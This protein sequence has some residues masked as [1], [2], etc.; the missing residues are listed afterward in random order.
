MTHPL[1]TFDFEVL[2]AVRSET[3]P[4]LGYLVRI[5]GFR[6]VHL[7]LRLAEMG[8]VPTF[9]QKLLEQGSFHFALSA[10]DLDAFLA[11]AI[12]A[13]PLADPL[14]LEDAEREAERLNAAFLSERSGDSLIPDS[15]HPHLP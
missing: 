1:V 10:K 3:R 2:R 12:N 13:R 14:P 4:L 5:T 6:C 8:K 11:A 9:R 15:N 7:V